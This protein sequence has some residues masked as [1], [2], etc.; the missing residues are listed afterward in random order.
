MT[1][2]TLRVSEEILGVDDEL[3]WT[4]ALTVQYA[5]ID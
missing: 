1:K 4:W 2:T 5:L 3:Y